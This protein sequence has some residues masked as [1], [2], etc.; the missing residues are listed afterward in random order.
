[1]SLH[2]GQVVLGNVVAAFH[3]QG[4]SGIVYSGTEFDRLAAEV[5]S[6]RAEAAN[7]GKRFDDLPRERAANPA[8]VRIVPVFSAVAADFENLPADVRPPGLDSTGEKG[9]KAAVRAAQVAWAKF[10]YGG[11]YPH[12]Q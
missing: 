8:P 5:A 10:L 3:K 11:A 7:L 1:M 2:P 6:L 12:E 4:G 9:A